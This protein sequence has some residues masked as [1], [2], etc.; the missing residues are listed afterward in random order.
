[1]TASF[2]IY[3]SINRKQTMKTALSYVKKDSNLE[4]ILPEVNNMINKDSS[5]EANPEDVVGRNRVDLTDFCS[6]CDLVIDNNLKFKISS[7]RIK[8]ATG[9]NSKILFGKLP[10]TSSSSFQI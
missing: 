3:F 10:L 6:N 1:M 8:N 2:S 4:K 7:E 9:P 5:D